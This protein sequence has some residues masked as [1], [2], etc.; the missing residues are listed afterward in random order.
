MHTTEITF[1]GVSADCKHVDGQP[2]HAVSEKYLTAVTEIAGGIPLIIP[3]LARRLDL[4]RLLERLDGLLLTGSLS[5]LH[6]EYY[7]TAASSEH[8]PFDHARDAL[9]LGQTDAP[10]LIPL[11]LERGLPLLAICRGFQELNVAFGG[12]LHPAIHHIPGRLDH[13]WPES[14]DPAQQYGPQHSVRFIADGEFA[15]RFA[16]DEIQVNSLHR[17]GID[18]LGQGLTAEGYAPDG[19]IEAL[20][21][22]NAL[23][24]ALGVQW[25]PE[26]RAAENPFSQRLFQSFGEAARDYVR[27]R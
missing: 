27:G 1:I 2:N 8:E 5:N 18:Q 10:G 23:G 17:Q 25:H 13:R 12:T 19:T 22:N 15:R 4:E 9:T 7:A 3:A 16:V 21:V 14:E 26:Y 11:A 20:S 6:P 24:F